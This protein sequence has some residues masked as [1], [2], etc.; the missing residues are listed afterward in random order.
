VKLRCMVACLLWCISAHGAPTLAGNEADE[1]FRRGVRLVESASWAQALEAFEHAS[2]IAPHPV[3]FYNMALCR[4]ALGQ[5]LRAIDLLDLAL[6]DPREGEATLAAATREQAIALRYEL[7]ATI[8]HIQIDVDAADTNVSVDGRPLELRG[9]TSYA[10]TLAPGEGLSVG[11]RTRIAA[12]DPGDHTWIFSRKGFQKQ[13]HYMHILPGFSGH[14]AI[15]LQPLPSTLIIEAK[16]PASRVLLNRVF[17]GLTPLRIQHAP[18][19]IDVRVDKAGFAPFETRVR[20]LPGDLTQV[21]VSQTEATVP[22]T[23]KWWFYSIIGA[24]AAGIG[25]TTYVLLQPR[26]QP[27]GGTLNWVV[28]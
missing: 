14:I 2:A 10:G 1:A 15:V 9:T 23:K 7:G 25:V 5:T 20:L 4:R 22:I 12:I 28:R 21:S 17:V 13:V 6:A 19:P 16:Q 18:G 11:A 3:T 24:M 8:G 26:Q 27:D